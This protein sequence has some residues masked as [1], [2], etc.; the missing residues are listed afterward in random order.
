M[1]TLASGTTTMNAF[2]RSASRI[3][4][5]T[6]IIDALDQIRRGRRRS[7]LLLLVA[8]ALSSRLSG[9]GTVASLALR[10]FRRFR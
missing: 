4:T 3:S 10:L 1:A 9:L 7:G 8:A 6:T 5:V 2:G